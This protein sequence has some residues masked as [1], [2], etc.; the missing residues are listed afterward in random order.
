MLQT[1]STIPCLLALLLKVAKPNGTFE[2]RLKNTDLFQWPHKAEM[3]T[4]ETS[5][6][7]IALYLPSGPWC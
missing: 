7:H 1:D 5:H 6:C 4:I 3:F 2:V